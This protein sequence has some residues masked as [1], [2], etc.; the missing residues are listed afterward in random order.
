[1][2][3]CQPWVGAGRALIIPNF[4]DAWLLHPIWKLFLSS[5]KCL[6]YRNTWHFATNLH[7]TAPNLSR[8][9]FHTS[10]KN[11]FV[12]GSRSGRKCLFMCWALQLLSQLIRVG[13][14]REQTLGSSG[15]P[16]FQVCSQTQGKERKRRWDM[17]V[18][19]SL[20][21]EIPHAPVHSPGGTLPQDIHDISLKVCTHIGVMKEKFNTASF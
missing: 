14:G 17:A 6:A 3:H 16:A 2:R 15:I 9:M 11:K 5:G 19:A 7:K 21:V 10:R 13:A 4:R 8:S 18:W 12:A 20:P 1:M